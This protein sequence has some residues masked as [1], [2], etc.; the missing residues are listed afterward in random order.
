MSK[1]NIIKRFIYVE[2]SG[3][4]FSY[5]LLTG[6]LYVMTLRR[7]ENKLP[8]F[9]E[10]IPPVHF[11]AEGLKGVEDYKGVSIIRKRNGQFSTLMFKAHLSEVLK[12][13]KGMEE[14]GF[15]VVETEKLSIFRYG[16]V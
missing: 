13:L 9:L 2:D 1:Q 3:F 5:R 11:I 4:R 12:G 14:Q 7:Y 8:L 16:G 15:T 10:Q 6:K